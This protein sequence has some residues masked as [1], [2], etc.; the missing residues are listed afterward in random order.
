MYQTC[1]QAAVGG[2]HTCRLE[3][4]VE[5]DQHCANTRRCILQQKQ[6][7]QGGLKLSAALVRQQCS[8]LLA[9]RQH[10]NPTNFHQA[11]SVCI[12]V[13]A[14]TCST[15]HSAQLGAHTPTR[16]RRCSRAR[17]G[18]QGARWVGSGWSQAA[19]AYTCMSHTVW[20]LKQQRSARACT[21]F[22]RQCMQ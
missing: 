16:S 13:C 11:A 22:G 6:R 15:T 4:R 5:I 20:Q 12:C 17:P 10:R 19:A 18:R 14:P 9:S 7:Q 1:L 8:C 21:L 3:G 2:A